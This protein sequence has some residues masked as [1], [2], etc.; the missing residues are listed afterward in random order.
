MTTSSQK[1]IRRLGFINE[2]V[3]RVFDNLP[4]NVLD[5]PV[6]GYEDIRTLLSNIEVASDLTDNESNN[7]KFKNEMA[8]GGYVFKGDKYEYVPTKFTYT[9]GGL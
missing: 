2:D 9:I 7:W 3:K 5:M 8:K 6:Y 1:I 4:E